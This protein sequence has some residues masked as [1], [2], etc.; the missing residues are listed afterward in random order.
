MATLGNPK[1]SK[2]LYDVEVRYL[3]GTRR[4]IEV[5]ANNRDQASR[6]ANRFDFEVCSVN[7]VG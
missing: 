5:Y 7:M 3:D 6:I 1:T 4:T 2:H